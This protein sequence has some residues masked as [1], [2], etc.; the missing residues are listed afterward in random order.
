MKTNVFWPM[1]SFNWSAC[2]VPLTV[3]REYALISEASF[4][5][6]SLPFSSMNFLVCCL[7]ATLKN[8]ARCHQ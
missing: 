2:T 8:A 4:S 3:D 5:F 6:G 1:A 7:I